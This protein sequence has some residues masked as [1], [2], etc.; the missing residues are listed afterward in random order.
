MRN[1]P[2]GHSIIDQ[3][4]VVVAFSALIAFYY[5]IL[6]LEMTDSLGMSDAL[7]GSGSLR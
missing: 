3:A 5:F 7:V 6:E 2:N 4:W 1:A